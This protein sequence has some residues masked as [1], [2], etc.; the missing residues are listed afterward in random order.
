MKKTMIFSFIVVMVMGIVAFND[1]SATLV[2]T[3]NYQ[4]SFA[5]ERKQFIDEIKNDLKGVNT[6]RADSIFKNLKLFKGEAG[7]KLTHFLGVMNYWGRALGVSC[8]YCHDPKN[9]ASENLMTKET[10]RGM[11]ELRQQI[12][13]QISLNIKGLNEVKPLV[14]CGTC[15]QGKPIPNMD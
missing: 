6:E 15:H 5:L 8:T 1:H 9:W 11:F 2:S 10:A 13:K 3:V 7:L 14:N 12:N 4:D